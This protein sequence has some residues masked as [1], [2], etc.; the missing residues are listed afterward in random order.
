[1]KSN[2]LILLCASLLIACS[3]PPPKNSIASIADNFYR[4]ECHTINPGSAST[5]GVALSYSTFR[6]SAQELCSKDKY[7]QSTDLIWSHCKKING[8][9]I[10]YWCSVNNLP[11]FYAKPG[12]IVEPSNNML[13]PKWLEY[14]KKEGFISPLDQSLIEIKKSA[15]EA[16]EIRDRLKQENK[17]ANELIKLYHCPEVAYP[18]EYISNAFISFILKEYSWEAPSIINRLSGHETKTIN[19]TTSNTSLLHY[20]QDFF[21]KV[22]ADRHI[23]YYKKY[24]S[25][26][27]YPEILEFW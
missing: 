17:Q 2:I 13:D 8:V 5:D 9:K 12:H 24:S 20:Q 19:Y 15:K 3:T 22:I 11:A 27:E 23:A 21:K 26:P 14:S 1:M 25:C 18:K 6:G 7:S 10:N 4:S 16:E